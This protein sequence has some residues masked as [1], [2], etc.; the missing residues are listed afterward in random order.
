ML[1]FFT[2]I[3]SSLLLTACAHVSAPLP[4]GFPDPT[5]EG[6]IEIKTYPVM[7]TDYHAQGS[8]GRADVFFLYEDTQQGETGAYAKTLAQLTHIIK[9]CFF[10]MFWRSFLPRSAEPSLNSISV[11]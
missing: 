7:I 1:R 2:G 9:R 3:L 11:S 6:Q 10:R 5:P 8:A 4:E